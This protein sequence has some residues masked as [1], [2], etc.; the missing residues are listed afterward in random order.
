MARG[1]N[2]EEGGLSPCRSVLRW[3]VKGLLSLE[4]DNANLK[5]RASNQKKEKETK[6]DEEVLY[7]AWESQ[8]CGAEVAGEREDRKNLLGF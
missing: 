5:K 7:V 1:F 6:K 3:S 8:Y 2:R 4:H